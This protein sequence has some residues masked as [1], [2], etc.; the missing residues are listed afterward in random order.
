MPMSKKTGNLS[1]ITKMLS[2]RFDKSIAMK[3]TIRHIK[4]LPALF[5]WLFLVSCNQTHSPGSIDGNREYS[6]INRQLS[7]YSEVGIK[8]N[9]EIELDPT[10]NDHVSINAD[11]NLHN[12]IYT[13][14]VDGKLIISTPENRSLN[15][16]RDIHIVVGAKTLKS[17]QIEGSNNLSSSTVIVFDTLKLNIAGASKSSLKLTGK[18]LEGEFPGAVS[19]ELNGYVKKMT[20]NLA[21]AAKLNSFDLQTSIC[22]INL[23]G[24]AKADI[25]ATD[26][27]SV[28]IAGVGLVN[29]K[30]NPRKVL[31]TIGGIGKLQQ[32][33]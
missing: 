2:A 11:S 5:I 26:T 3:T 12:Y 21:G 20:I 32:V 27:L 4:L 22:Y 30:G 10:F 31:S 28:N 1:L 9:F 25:Y 18:V 6:S 29:Y 16:L 23:A 8:G 13:E 14:V 17:L 7:P 24:A 15:S 19:L 33:D